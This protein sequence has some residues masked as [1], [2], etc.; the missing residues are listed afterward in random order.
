MSDRLYLSC[1]IRNFSESNMLKHFEKLLDL[2]PFSRLAQRPM[3]LRVYAVEYAEPPVMEHTF[4]MGVTARD[5]VEA[6]RDFMKSDCCM[7]IDAAWDLWQHDGEWA[8]QPASVTLTCNG[9]DFER[10]DD[11][12]LRIDFG[13]DAKF[14]P[15]PGLEGS[16]RMGQ[17]NLRSLVHLV[18]DLERVLPMQRRQVWSESGA[19]FAQL[20]AEAVSQFDV[21]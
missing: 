9:P 3:V 20:L 15:T 5:M 2:F 11:D 14:L 12:D 4:E 16:L 18:T 21:Q 7:E 6:A 19:S 1:W 10:D 17:S 13:L 8:L